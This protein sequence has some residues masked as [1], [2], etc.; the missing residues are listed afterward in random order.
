[1]SDSNSDDATAQGDD[2]PIDARSADS[3]T[4]AEGDRD[5]A[6]SEGGV[7][8]RDIVG[9][10]QW[11]AFAILC[12][13]ALVATFRFYFAASEAIRVWFSP[14]FVPVF[15]AVFNLVVLAASAIGISVLVRRIA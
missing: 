3:G 1:M 5:P 10:V 11:A 15:Q 7:D 8:G 14:D 4:A 13:L 9:Y 2:Q 6:R 12:L